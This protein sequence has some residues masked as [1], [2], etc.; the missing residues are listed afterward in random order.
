MRPPARIK[1]VQKLMGCLA[2]LSQFI[3]RLA[4]WA[5]SFFKFLR[6]SGHFIWTDEVEEAFQE[7]KW[8]LTSMPVMVAPEPGEPL[9][10]YIIVAAEAMSMVL[11]TKRSEPL[12]PQQIN[13]TS[14]NISGSYDPEPARSPDVG[15]TARS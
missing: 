3:S 14:M 10:L 8:Y 7:L 9:L 13:E 15:I 12:Q 11:V 4:E 6:K 1:D 5:L 2:M